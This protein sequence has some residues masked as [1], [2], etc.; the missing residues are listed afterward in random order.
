MNLFKSFYKYRGNNYLLISLILLLIYD[1][2][3]FLLD[4]S[5]KETDTFKELLFSAKFLMLL[6][7]T[8]FILTIIVIN[9][10][11][12]FSYSKKL[13]EISESIINYPYDARS[14]FARGNMYYSGSDYDAAIDD[15]CSA[16]KLKPDFAEAY[17]NRG[18]AFNKTNESISFTS[19]LE[20]WEK[21]KKLGLEPRKKSIYTS[22]ES[23]EN[24]DEV[25]DEY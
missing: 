18:N 14:F 2:Y 13:K 6:I 15:Y 7:F 3:Y 25:M 24:F 1:L 20:D 21:A 17:N 19:A 8:L 16:I 9:T 11:K 22:I 23:N 12:W 10:V 5:F 4:Y